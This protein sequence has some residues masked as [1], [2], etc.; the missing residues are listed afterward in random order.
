MI[1]S[2]LLLIPMLGCMTMPTLGQ[3]PRNPRSRG[4][5]GQIPKPGSL[6]PTVTIVNE[7]GQNF[8]TAMLRGSY[9]VLVFGCLT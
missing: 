3:S 9:T 2:A 8:S 4:G 7:Q 5:G 1:R 6:L